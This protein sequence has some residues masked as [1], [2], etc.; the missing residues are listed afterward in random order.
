MQ[1]K[2]LICFFKKIYLYLKS[3]VKVMDFRKTIIALTIFT[4][5]FLIGILTRD[6]VVVYSNNLKDRF[7]PQ[8]QS[9]NIEIDIESSRELH[10][11]YNFN[12]DLQ[13]ILQLAYETDSIHAY[14]INRY[15][16]VSIKEQDMFGFPA[17]VKLAQFLVEGGYSKS[18]P[19]GSK[20]VI[21][22]NNPFGIK[23]FGNSVPDRIPN[24]N[25]YA[26]TNQFVYA[27]D[28]CLGKCKFIKFKAVWHSFRY[29]SIFVAGT[30][31]NPSHYSKHI[32]NGDWVD[33]LNA[34]EKGGYATSQDYK[35]TLR[36]V[37]IR[38]KLYLLDDYKTIHL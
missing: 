30:D 15:A 13:S 6:S 25:E 17:S 29:H 8:I 18:N 36:S 4:F 34:L 12:Q 3:K 2:K 23:Y 7:T 1:K 14:Y 5:G 19:K 38:Y 21:E 33:W 32:T 16:K 20:L 24:W 31:Q 22:G 10:K 11:K 28:D 26:Y 9:Y 27:N 35:S 37:I